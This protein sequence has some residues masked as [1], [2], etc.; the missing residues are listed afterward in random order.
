M[1]CINTE[2]HQVGCCLKKQSTQDLV[3]LKT[4]FTVWFAKLSDQ[5]NRNGSTNSVSHTGIRPQR[6]PAFLARASGIASQWICSRALVAP[7]SKRC[8][9]RN[10][11]LKTHHSF[12]GLFLVSY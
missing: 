4:L 10:S 3:L 6:M 2:K 1:K 12:K 5:E 7:Y 9:T 11:T 8:R